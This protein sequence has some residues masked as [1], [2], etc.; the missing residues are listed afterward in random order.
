MDATDR[1]NG[2]RFTE[3]EIYGVLS[4]DILVSAP[5]LL[6]NCKL[7]SHT[8]RTHL[9]ERRSTR[10]H[11]RIQR[12]SKM[13]DNQSEPPIK[14]QKKRGNPNL[15]KKGRKSLYGRNPIAPKGKR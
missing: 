12:L 11:K 4:G 1:D 8:L 9:T 14:K 3:V 5:L 7:Y 10:G 2:S 15:N 6:R 13:E